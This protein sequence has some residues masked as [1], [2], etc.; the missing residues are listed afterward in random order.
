MLIA[1]GFLM[2]LLLILRLPFIQT[3]IVGKINLALSKQLNTTVA[4]NSVSLNFIDNVSLQGIYLEDQAGDTLLYVKSLEVDMAIFRLLQ[5]QIKIEDIQLEGSKIRIN[6]FADSTYN[7]SFI[8][9]AF[10]SEDTTTTPFPFDIQL[11]QIEIL[12]A[13]Y[14]FNSLESSNQL[15]FKE[16]A[17]EANSIDINT[18]TFELDRITLDGLNLASNWEASDEQADT[19]ELTSSESLPFPLL[20]LPIS[21]KC[22]DLQIRHS[23]ASYQKGAPSASPYFNSNSIQVE[24]LTIFVSDLVLEDTLLNFKIKNSQLCLNEMK[25]LNNFNAVGF[26]SPNR[27]ALASENWTFSE[28]Q[29]A[30]DIQASYTTFEDLVNLAATTHTNLKIDS[31]QLAVADLIY[32]IPALDS[33]KVIHQLANEKISLNA[34]VDGKLGALNVHSL[35][36]ATMHS[37]VQLNGLVRNVN[38]YEKLNVDDLKLEAST[39]VS[40][41]RTALGNE[42]VKT[43][44]DRFG[45]INLDTRLGGSLDQVRISELNIQT[46]GDLKTSFSGTLSQIS[47]L[48]LFSYD[49]SVKQL[50]TSYNDAIS[51]SDALPAMLES[52]DFVNY[53]GKLRGNLQ[54]FDVDG[55]LRSSLGNVDL[56]LSA[57]F[58]QDY[59]NAAYKGRVDVID[60]QLGQLLQNDSL[61]VLSLQADVD[62]EGL[63]LET[64]DARINV[65]VSEFTFNSYLYHQ[66]TINGHINQQKFEGLVNIDDENVALDFE[67]L[68]NLEDTLPVFNFEVD[69]KRLN[70]QALNLTTFP[71][72]VSLNISSEL[73]GKTLDDINGDLVIRAIQ[74]VN[75]K[76]TWK[77]DSIVFTAINGAGLNREMHLKSEVV[78]VDL[79]GQYGIENLPKMLLAFGDQHFPFSSLIGFEENGVVYSD[80]T[81]QPMNGEFVKLKATV[82]ELPELASF[83]DVDLKRLDSASLK[84]E[85]DGTNKLL[86]FEFFIPT[87]DYQNIHIDSVY[88][89]ANTSNGNLNAR[90]SIDS[91]SYGDFAYVPGL[92]TQAEFRDQIAYVRTYIEN[93]TGSYSLDLNTEL[94]NENA[95]IGIRLMDPFMLNTRLWKITQTG[96]LLLADSGI[97]LPQVQLN[98]GKQELAF[99]SAMDE[100]SLNFKDFDLNNFLELVEIDSFLAKGQLNG[101]LKINTSAEATA[102]EGD[103]SLD[104]FTVNEVEIGNVKIDA[105]V[106]ENNVLAEF[107]LKGQDNKL[108]ANLSYD[109]NETDLKGQVKIEKINLPNFEPFLQNFASNLEGS[110]YGNLSISGKTAAP[111][112]SGQVNFTGVKA[113]VKAAGTTYGIGLGY[114]ELSEKLLQPNLTLLDEE[115]RKATLTGTI[116][117]QFFDAF[118]F[119]LNLD[120]EAFTFLNSKKDVDNL[121]YGK[122]VASAHLTIGGDL[123]LPIVRGKIGTLPESD[124]TV[125]LLSERAIA[126]QESYVIFLNGADYSKEEIDS[127]ANERY[128]IS[129]SIDLSL[130]LDVNDKTILN[131][132][133]DPITGDKLAV[134][135]NGQLTLKIPPKGD[136]D[137]N[138][139]YTVTS[140][141]YNFSFQR[142]L[143]RKFEIVNGSQIV[144]SGNPMN[145]RLSLKAA[146]N[147][148]ASTYPLVQGQSG[149]LSQ[150][151][152]SDIKKKQDVRVELNI[153]GK[154]AEP[155]LSFNINLANTGDSP[156]GSSA[157]RALDQLKQNE[158]ELNKQVFSL[159]LFNSFSGS[160]SSGNISSTGS[161]TAVRSVGNLISTQLNRLASKAEGLQ[162][163]FD[164]D[165]YADQLSE[166][167]EQITEIDLG[168]SQSLL[169]DRLVISVGGNVDLET[170]NQSKSSLGNVAGDFVIEYKLSD[171][172]KYKVRV[173][174]KSDYDALN[175][176]NLWK[177]GA[178][179]SYQ[180]KFGK[181]R[182]KKGGKQ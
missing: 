61:G 16:L 2:L 72:E 148:E 102:F 94:Y 80:S 127:I 26:F 174:Q 171:D 13:D 25:E 74:L 97:V 11:G 40:D 38:E 56:D 157:K 52:F 17:L 145:A 136:I 115:N 156:V 177:T 4:I 18:L 6:Q 173:F 109:V 175:D 163:N 32:F 168:I 182:K 165:Q 144:F 36:T 30:F 79:E 41:L 69:L 107:T 43:A 164:L 73:T 57:A 133:I 12:N 33:I 113:F 116:E 1:L 114:V 22:K 64:I 123:A 176:A 70:T 131:L 147:T 34:D 92:A 55:L 105:S 139:V 167:N 142:L 125:Q 14:T 46:S 78:N 31:L 89:F 93:D 99:E 75:D 122:F 138:G 111:E 143:K 150:S 103:L 180:T 82:H 8:L 29:F 101:F 90:F 35:G 91:A 126:T 158:T 112:F 166:N 128:Q 65:L 178:G 169:D 9:D 54:S 100:Y 66:L 51:I 53:Q 10:A 3:F 120:S 96:S 84:L 132:V 172:G 77:T 87:I 106:I 117:H 154:L 48:D 27:I 119:K 137:I 86:D 140:G 135:G 81:I 151:E 85:L 58:N 45:T 134:Q 160:T 71:L 104:K 21:I 76:H 181:L 42:L 149:G 118:K 28:S 162:I 60:F 170:G 88:M 67:G 179:F 62:G 15:K 47:N 63:S 19:P 7:F 98:N 110:L 37:K 124:I 5:K 129:T 23:K 108:N 68:V 49:I 20:G 39:S 24:D 50:A 44:Y 155:E 161:S 121:F 130:L 141:Q 153:N 159:L 152:E 146:Y 59:S 95:A 83:F